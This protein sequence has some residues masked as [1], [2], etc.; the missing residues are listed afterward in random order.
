M[1]LELLHTPISTCS[2][3]VRMALFEKGL[4]WTSRPVNLRVHEHLTPEYLALNPNGVVPTLLHDGEAIVDSSVINEYLEDVFPARPLRPAEPKALARMRA[5]RAYIDEVPTTAIRVP[6]FQLFIRRGLPAG[7]AFDAHA[8]RLPLRK[9][10]Y[11][12]MRDGG[13]SETDQAEAREKLRQSIDRMEA[14]LADGRPWLCGD[15]F[16]LADISI[17]PSIVR[18]EDLGMAELWADRP[19]VTQWYARLRARPAFALAYADGAR[20]I[21]GYAPAPA[22]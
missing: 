1:S 11:G 21:F 8:A 16:T 7:A 14:A 12:K 20:D 19:L 2:Q 15:M 18:L 3:K 22:C 10:F 13:F 4:A 9:H 5:W 6:S 17:M